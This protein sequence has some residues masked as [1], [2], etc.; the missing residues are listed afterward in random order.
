MLTESCR[1]AEELKIKQELCL[2]MLLNS[3]NFFFFY[4]VG[5]PLPNINN[6]IL[7]LS[8]L[9]WCYA[10]FIQVT[11]WRR[12]QMGISINFFTPHWKYG[13]EDRG[14]KDVIDI[15]DLCKSKCCRYC[16]IG[17]LIKRG[18]FSSRNKGFISS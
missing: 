17:P 18:N 7:W 1:G 11:S 4:S 14:W 10:M 15:L 3:H 2:S 9:L 12:P 8:V 13:C 6:C 5:Q 16:K